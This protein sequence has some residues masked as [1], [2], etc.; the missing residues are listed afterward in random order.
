M[1]RVKR[2]DVPDR[3]EVYEP[4]CDPI[5]GTKFI[6]FKVPL[7]ESICRKLDDRS[8]WFTPSMLVEKLSAKG[9]KLGAII[10]LTNTQR[11]YDPQEIKSCGIEYNKLNT[12]GHVVPSKDVID[13][14]ANMVS[15]FLERNKGTDLL[16]GVHCTHGVNR[17]G[18]LICRYMIDKLGVSPDEAIQ[19]FNE[20][21]GHKIER[22]NYLAHLRGESVS[23]LDE[24]PMQGRS[25]RGKWKCHEKTH[26]RNRNVPYQHQ[27]RNFREQ[28]AFQPNQ[29]GWS[30]YQYDN[31]YN[32]YNRQYEK[33]SGKWISNLKNNGN[34][35]EGY[36][37]NRKG[38][39]SSRGG[40]G[41]SRGGYGGFRE[42][43]GDNR[44][45]YGG[46]RDGYRG[47]R[48]G[49]GGNG[50]EFGGSSD[51]YGGSRWENGNFVERRWHHDG[52]RGGSGRIREDF[53]GYRGHEYNK[54]NIY[55]QGE[56]GQF[57]PYGNNPDRY[58]WPNYSNIQ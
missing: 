35:R 2:R 55:S 41:G 49:Y 18:H 12:V 40:Y 51:G 17:S 13:S 45:R 32:V 43:R 56:G 11:Y 23:H 46:N 16:L 5:K 39:R 58:Y 54:H 26:G 27:N 15:S 6:A 19:A 3:W 42:G 21:R 28:G 38:Y 24:E 29:S 20:A 8:Q 57:G 22:E 34:S 25:H 37:G 10:D 48:N 33:D 7:K 9:K 50:E 53:R 47:S 52:Y 44:D 1:G 36:V 31:R 30:G 4:F 14:F